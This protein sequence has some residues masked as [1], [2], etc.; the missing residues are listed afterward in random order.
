MT[1]KI[2]IDVGGTFTDFVVA[3]DGAP[4]RIFKTLSTPTDP[5]VAVVRG[6]ADIA[7]SLDPPMTL[8]EFAPTIETIVHGTTV[9]TNA[10]LTSRGAKCGLLTTE[11]VR[12]ALEMR[13]GIREE[14]YNN[15]A[16]NVRPL[17]PR[18]LRRGIPGRVDRDG[19]AVQP[20]DLE[21][22]R[23]AI[24]LFRREDVQAVAICFMNSFAN[25]QHERTKAFLSKV[26]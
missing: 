17:V 22:V 3:R 4:P 9:T 13:R 14:Q 21:A 5:S 24:R 16:T 10:T 7:A 2:G 11:G 23:E 1:L 20:L 12:D 26:L 15:R 6:L 19:Q 18:A 8:A 25:P